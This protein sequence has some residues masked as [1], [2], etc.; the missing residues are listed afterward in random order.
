MLAALNDSLGALN[1]MGCNKNFLENVTNICPVF[2]TLRTSIKLIDRLQ[3]VCVIW[4]D[5]GRRWGD[6]LPTILSDCHFGEGTPAMQEHARNSARKAELWLRKAIRARASA[7]MYPEDRAAMENLA[8]IY[9]KLAE[10][11]AQLECKSAS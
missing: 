4:D 8:E 10:R 9:E 3:C 5:A 11:A 2:V 6:S 1:D 7:N